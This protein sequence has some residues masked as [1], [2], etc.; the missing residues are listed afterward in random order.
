MKNVIL[1]IC[2]TF[3]LLDVNCQ[4]NEQKIIDFKND[5]LENEKNGKRDTLILDDE[6]LIRTKFPDSRSI[7]TIFKNKNLFCFEDFYHGSNQLKNISFT[8]SM[9]NCVG[10]EKKYS[11][12]GELE[13]EMN[14][15]K[16]EWLIL[17]NE[18]YPSHVKLLNLK[19]VADSVINNIY[20]PTFLNKNTVWNISHSIAETFW[21]DYIDKRPLKYCYYYDV[22]MDS[23]YKN[24][25][26]IHIILDSMGHF[27]PEKSSGFEKLPKTTKKEFTLSYY[28]AI[29]KAKELGLNEFDLQ[30]IKGQLIWEIL[31]ESELFNGQF[32][33]YLMVQTGKNDFLNPKG[34]SSVVLRYEV[35]IFNPWNGDFIA[36]KK[37]KSMYSWEKHSGSSTGLIPDND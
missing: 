16:G 25:K 1:F 37:M 15:E 14:H 6:I 5:F 32:R 8:D 9:V 4:S 22:K 3:L 17:K 28:Y 29:N 34:R 20:G 21:D 10:V 31:N 13:W 23:C 30:N 26:T 19:K 33:F 35:Y 7:I 11:T 2:L 18:L 12:T 27:I 36:K 24:I